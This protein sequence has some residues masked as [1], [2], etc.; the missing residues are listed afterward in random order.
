[1]VL[2]SVSLVAGDAQAHEV[3]P[4]VADVEISGNQLKMQVELTIEPLL[5]GM[6]LAGLTNTNDS[7]LSGLYDQYR[8]QDGALLDKAF[9]AFWPTLRPKLIFE[10]DGERALAEIDELH[11]PPVG[12]PELPRDSTLILSVELPTGAEPVRVGWAA[13]LGP[14]ILRQSGE[15]D[16]LYSGYLTGGELSDPLPRSGVADIGAVEHFG[17]YV[18]LGFEHILPKG[19]D[20]ILFVLGLFF[21]SLRMRPLLVQVT[22]FTVAHTVTLALAALGVVSVSPAIVEP[23]IAASI[24]YVAIENI[25]RPKL[26]WWRTAVVFGFG[27]LHGL[28][29]ASVLGEIGLDPARFISGLIAFNIGVEIGQLTVIA[30]AFLAVGL[31]F[32]SRDWYR[33]FIAIPVSC[34]IAVVGAWWMVERT[35]I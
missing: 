19:L 12:N 30:L 4:A 25:L 32:G 5:A 20:H 14:L 27:L 24:T 2:S 35:L 16:E 17:R 15:G 8:K 22:A 11:I 23:M 34:V 10:I 7:P 18:V 21:F 3:R 13:E 26:G 28:G 1:M 9:R 31:W 6:N 33:P 29:F